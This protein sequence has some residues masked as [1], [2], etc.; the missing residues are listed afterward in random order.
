MLLNTDALSVL[1]RTKSSDS[2]SARRESTGF[3]SISPGKAVKC[4]RSMMAASLGA[5]DWTT[6]SGPTS[7][8]RSSTIDALIDPIVA[9]LHI[10]QSPGFDQCAAGATG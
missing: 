2:Y 10:E 9:G 8:M 4:V 3:A 7:L 5:C 1:F 6:E